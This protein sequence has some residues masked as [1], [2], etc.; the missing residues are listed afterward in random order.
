VSP[1]TAVLGRGRA[2]GSFG[3]AL[4][5]ADWE[6]VELPHDRA[7]EL[8]PDEAELVLLCVPDSAV[9]EVARAMDPSDVR[10]VAHCAGALDLAPLAPHPRRASVHP[11]VALTDPQRG[12]DALVGAWFAVAGDPLV[13]EVVAA[14]GGSQ[15]EVG[16]DDRVVYHAAAVVASNH[17][18]ALLGQ[19]QRLAAEIGVPLDAYLD[20]ARGT[21]DDVAAVG[22]AGALTGPVAR[23]DWGTVAAHLA[24][25]PA[26]EQ[27][28]YLA[29]AAAAAR[30]VGAT[31]PPELTG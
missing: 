4:R 29:L 2:G 23:Q 12:A 10:V 11:L 24:A 26:S 25:I 30:L 22:P 19:V 20:L 15:V 9:A 5:A 13:E 21:L 27:P 6:V 7:A 18:V 8:A 16:D 14:L 31:L 17:L 28:A 1:T 3:A